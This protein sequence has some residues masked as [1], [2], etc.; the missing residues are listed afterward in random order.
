MTELAVRL[1]NWISERSRPKIS[2][3]ISSNR[4][5]T[6]VVI[7]STDIGLWLNLQITEKPTAFKFAE[8][9]N[10]YIPDGSE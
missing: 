1:W 9:K 3:V 10:D 8:S 6:S 5:Y 7:Q 4:Y 2:K